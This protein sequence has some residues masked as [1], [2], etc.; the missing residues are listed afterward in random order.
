MTKV[1]AAAKGG[2]CWYRDTEIT[3]ILYLLWP[4]KPEWCES[5]GDPPHPLYHSVPGRYH[6]GVSRSAPVCHQFV[7]PAPKKKGILTILLMQCKKVR[8]RQTRS[9]KQWALFLTYRV[10]SWP[11]LIVCPWHW[12][13]HVVLSIF[14]I[15]LP[16]TSMI[17]LNESDQDIKRTATEIKVEVVLMQTIM[18]PLI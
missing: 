1:V 2:C 12:S 18:Q 3:P 14:I 15:W 9:W 11:C 5:A 8:T 16:V 13:I 6:P 10:T 17:K 4:E 7:Q